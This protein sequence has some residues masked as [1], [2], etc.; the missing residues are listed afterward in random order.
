MAASRITYK[1]FIGMYEGNIPVSIPT[2]RWKYNIKM[3]L[4]QV[5]WGGLDWI[6]LRIGDQ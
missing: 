6:C 1:L 3:D 4:I 5:G 2:H